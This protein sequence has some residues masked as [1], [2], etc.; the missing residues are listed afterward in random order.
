MW[1][2]KRKKTSMLNTLVFTAA[3]GGGKVTVP[4]DRRA[5]IE[6]VI[7]QVGW[8]GSAAR[9]MEWTVERQARARVDHRSRGASLGKSGETPGWWAA[10]RSWTRTAYCRLKNTVAPPHRLDPH[11]NRGVGAL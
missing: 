7:A 6:H 2:H 5:A 11:R 8:P 4:S 1:K 9:A 10:A 3:H